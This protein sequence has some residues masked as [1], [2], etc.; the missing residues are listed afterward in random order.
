[1]KRTLLVIAAMAVS[2]M[3][4]YGQGRILFN[5]YVSGNAISIAAGSAQD[6]A[7]Y[8]GAD[9]TVQ[10]LWAPGTLD[11]AAW[12]AAT[13]SSST[14]VAMF[15]A[16]GV[17]PGHGPAADGAGLFDGGTVA[18][19]GPGGTYTF[20]VV[21]WYNGGTYSTFSA[22]SAAGK[23]IGM[24]AL[25]TGN[26]TVSPTPAQNTTFPSFTLNSG[27]IIPEPSTFAL[28]GLGLAGLAIFR[29]RK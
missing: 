29:R 18:M 8:I 25:F 28:A 12:D 2:A 21:A 5:N 17:A 26:A 13:K 23:N 15:G 10:L 1:M 22:A 7:A 3:T 6:P 20:Q 19:G 11:Q 14:A 9:Y 16:T 4:M 27:A 24:S